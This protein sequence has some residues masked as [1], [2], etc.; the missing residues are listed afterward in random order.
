VLVVGVGNSGAEIAY[1]VCKT[2]QTWLSGKPS[3]ELPFKHGPAMARFV[4]PVVRFIGHHVLTMRN[5]LGRKVG[6]NF[7]THAAPLIR[8][9][10]K[11][12]TNAGV[13]QVGRTVGVQDGRPVLDDGRVLDVANVIWCTGFRQDYSWI[14]VPAFDESGRPIHKRGVAEQ[15]PGLYFMG[16]LF[17]FAASSDVLPGVG[18]D[19]EYVAKHIASR[20]SR[21]RE[22]A[23]VTA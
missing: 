14:D 16:L 19:A 5:P 7:V 17:Q 8:V 6:P 1:E 13:E 2:H 12:L 21:A 23:T 4:F 22:T 15:S 18:R 20:R 3:A 10:T 11:H 9:K